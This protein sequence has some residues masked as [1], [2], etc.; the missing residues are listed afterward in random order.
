[1]ET[2]FS[3]VILF[4]IL[5]ALAAFVRSDLSIPEPLSKALSIYLMCAIGL[6]GGT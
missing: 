5:G 3:P 2:L 1:M 4:F 6:K